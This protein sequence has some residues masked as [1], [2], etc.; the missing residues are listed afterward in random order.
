M[1][2]NRREFLG[3]SALLG[4]GTLYA[5]GFW[6]KKPF[7]EWT[8]EEVDRLLTDSPWAKQLTVA[9][10]F[11]PVRRP[12]D[13][14]FDSEFS[15]Q[16]LPQGVG[17]PG[18]TGIPGI[19][20]VSWPGSRQPGGIPGAQIPKRGGGSAPVR[21]EIFLTVRWSS[22]LPVRRALAMQ[23]WGKT[24][25]SG[26]E[27]QEFLARRIDGYEIEIFGFPVMVSPPSE[28]IEKDLSKSAAIEV[29]KHPAAR[30][31]EVEVPPQGEH[32]SARLA[33][34][35]ISN[36][37]AADGYAELGAATGTMKIRCRF[38]LKEMFYE[39]QLAL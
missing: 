22:A 34:D 30:P 38:T 14:Q 9:F 8:S 12:S 5:A 27:A 24:G 10:E 35:A 37:T 29:K 26:A 31:R 15:D 4:T 33:F 21:T 1:D 6:D 23:R 16:R 3:A 25:I 18:G 20:G 13:S 11:R 39:G 17:L 19:G 28:Q 36:L 2:I 7:R 32:L